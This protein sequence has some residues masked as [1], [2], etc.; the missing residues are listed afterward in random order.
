[1]CAH[2]TLPYFFSLGGER[3][4]AQ[5]DGNS[6]QTKCCPERTSPGQ[7]AGIGISFSCGSLPNDT[8][9]EEEWRL[10]WYDPHEK[11]L[12]LGLLRLAIKEFPKKVTFFVFPSMLNYRSSD[13]VLLQ[14]SQG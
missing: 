7:G 14:S 11:G 10:L 13:F 3:T 6:C 4:L 1:M 5:H 2:R 9:D 8:N 12:P